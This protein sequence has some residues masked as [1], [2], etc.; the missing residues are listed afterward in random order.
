[1]AEKRFPAIL[2]YNKARQQWLLMKVNGV[3]TIQEFQ[4]LETCN[5]INDLVKLTE[6]DKDID[7]PVIIAVEKKNSSW[8]KMVRLLEKIG[9]SSIMMRDK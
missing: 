3:D 7:N 2:R 4:Y 8:L 9:M 5:F 1:M 6:L